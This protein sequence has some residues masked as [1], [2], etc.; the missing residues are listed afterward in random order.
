LR[1]AEAAAHAKVG[2]IAERVYETA[3]PAETFGHLLESSTTTDLVNRLDLLNEL[4]YTGRLQLD[5]LTKAAS[6]YVREK[7]RLDVF[8]LAESNQYA[9][10]RTSRTDIL[11]EIAHLKSLRFAAYGSTG[12]PGDPVIH[13]LPVFTA[14]AAGKAVQFAYAQLGKAYRFGASGPNSTT[15]PV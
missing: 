11:A 2:A 4:A 10:L 9:L 13:Y 6:A 14:G 1:R 15:V 7:Q 5:D 12:S 8:D 3:S